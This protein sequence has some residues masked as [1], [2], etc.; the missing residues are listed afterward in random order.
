MIWNTDLAEALELENLLEQAVVDP[1][2]RRRTAPKA[3]APMRA[4]TIPSATTATGSSTRSSG[5]TPTARSRL[6]YRPV[7]LYT[8]SNEVQ[9]FP[10]KARVY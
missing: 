7:H 6:G 4:R 8:L 2:F 5:S 9:P 1:A 3:A 10:P